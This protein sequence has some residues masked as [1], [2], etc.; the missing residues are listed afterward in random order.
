MEVLHP[1][2]LP[3]PDLD[4]SAM[5][6]MQRAIARDAAFEDDLPFDPGAVRWLSAEQT[7][8]GDTDSESGS[9]SG[10]ESNTSNGSSTESSE[11]RSAD[12]GSAVEAEAGPGPG[13]GTGTDGTTGTPV[14]VGV[15]QA[16]REEE[17]VS[18][19][20]AFRGGEPIE[21]AVGRAP[22]ELPY[23]PGLL[24]FREAPAIVDALEALSVA[25]DLL[26]LDGSGRIHFRQ[27]GLATHVG[28]LFDC[29]AVGV[30]K[31]LLCGTPRESLADPLPEG[32]RVAIEADADVERLDSRGNGERG[33]EGEAADAVIGYAY[34]SRQ[35]PNP[36]RRHVNPLYV[37]PGHRTGEETAVDL[38]E[39]LC[40]GYKL[41]EP[42]RL[43][44]SDADEATD[45]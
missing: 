41:P 13:T 38:I 44:D 15:D 19:A 26:V 8:L 21:R 9:R 20:L 12:D 33:A 22:L 34:Q 16:F 28:V 6:E 2:F 30:A 14:V 45:F 31:N 1:E 24:S 25:P 23:V 32:V 5:E 43:A 37:S 27:A 36:E 7:T 3:D 10:N 17:A 40:A 18:A 39:R 42:T 4:R 35:Y 11:R 29:P